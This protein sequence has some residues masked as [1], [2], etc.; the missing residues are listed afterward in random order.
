MAVQ[1]GPDDALFTEVLAGSRRTSRRR[2][3]VLMTIVGIAQAV[4]VGLICLIPIL[5]PS[6]LPSHPDALLT[7]LIYDP[8]PPPPL[9]LPKGSALQPERAQPV[10]PVVE[11]PKEL[12]FVAPVE[13]VTPDEPAPL[14]PEPGVREQDQFGSPTGSDKGRAVGMEGG[15][16]EGVPGGTLGGVPGGVIGGTGTG[17]VLDYDAGPRIIRQ[18]KPEYPHEAFVTKLEGTVVF[19]ILIDESGHVVRARVVQSIPSLDGAARKAVM[20]WLFEP[21]VKGG[22]RVATIANAPVHFRIF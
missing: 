11:N 18:T 12:Q 9:P 21:A 15:V 1:T 17:P 7:V 14:V 4:A 22:R 6:P 8:P 20:Q 16:D 5:T 19:E 10:E 2:V 3:S 13:V